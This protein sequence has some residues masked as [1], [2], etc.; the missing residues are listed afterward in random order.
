MFFIDC[1][2]NGIYDCGNSGKSMAMYV[3]YMV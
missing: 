1:G 3:K 2:G